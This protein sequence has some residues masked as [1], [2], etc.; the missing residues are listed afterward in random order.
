MVE[1]FIER[2]FLKK[3]IFSW[4]D[5]NDCLQNH[6]KQS[7]ELI[8][9]QGQKFIASENPNL[10]VNDFN[11]IFTSAKHVKKEFE[12]IQKFLKLKM[13]HLNNSYDW[14]TH[15]YTGHQEGCNSFGLHFDT[16]DNFIL[17]V[18]GKSRWIV[19]HYIDTVL[20]PGDLIWIPRFVVHGC[21]PLSKRISLSFPFWFDNT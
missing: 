4:N 18:I 13:P 16:A 12:E 8:D 15:I 10:N 11:V 14:D 20:N 1:P 7:L 5:F 9:K 21:Q 3:E 2:S 19:P 6:P 17:Q